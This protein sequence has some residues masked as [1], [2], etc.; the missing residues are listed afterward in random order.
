VSETTGHPEYAAVS[1]EGDSLGVLRDFPD[2]VKSNL[3]FELRKVQKGENPANCRPLPGIGVGLWELREQDAQTWY[4]LA[5]M[6]RRDDKVHVL[7]CFEK[8][9]NDIPKKE[10]DTIDRRFRSVKARLLE[11]KKGGKQS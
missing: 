4:R 5:Y 3:G 2:E 11:E 1:W 7:H 10:S 6:P 8:H 9:G